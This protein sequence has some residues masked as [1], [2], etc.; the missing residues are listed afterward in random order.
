MTDKVMKGRFGM[1][2]VFDF[3]SSRFSKAETK[4]KLMA[5]NEAPSCQNPVLK[6]GCFHAH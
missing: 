5:G 1:I 3:G 2:H 4:L 6:L